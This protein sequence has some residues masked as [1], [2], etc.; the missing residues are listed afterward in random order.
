ERQLNALIATIE[1]FCAKEESLQSELGSDLVSQLTVDEQITIDK[2][3]DTIEEITQELKEII[4]KRVELD[5]TK[6]KLEHQIAN[7]YRKNRNQI[8]TDLER[9][10]IENVRSVIEDLEREYTILS[11]KLNEH[12]KQTDAIDRIINNLDKE[13][14]NKQKE[15]EQLK[16]SNRDIDEHI[17]EEKRNADK[18][19]VK[20]RNAQNK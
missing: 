13:L 1:Q 16:N 4:K 2:L 5:G 14:K 10:H 3:N 15:L 9:M 18:Y 19:E 7:N 12:E 11:D 6:T 17:N 8:N 20:L